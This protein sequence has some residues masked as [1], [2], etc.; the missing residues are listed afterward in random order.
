MLAD[1]HHTPSSS[2]FDRRRHCNLGNQI[3]SPQLIIQALVAGVLDS[4]LL[5]S[6]LLKTIRGANKKVKKTSETPIYW[7]TMDSTRVL[8]RNTEKRRKKIWN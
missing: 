2:F 3:Y 1:I 6:T 7:H 4:F 8:M 5:S